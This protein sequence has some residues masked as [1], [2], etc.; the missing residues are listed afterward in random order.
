MTSSLFTFRCM[1]FHVILK[2]FYSSSFSSPP[3]LYIL[4][5][6]GLHVIAE[7]SCVLKNQRGKVVF[8]T[9][10]SMLY[11]KTAPDKYTSGLPPLP[12]PS[13][14]SL[15]QN[16]NNGEA[17]GYARVAPA[18]SY[19]R[20]SSAS[21]HSSSHYDD[22]SVG[23]PQVP[24]QGSSSLCVCVCLKACELVRTLFDVNVLLHVTTR[25]LSNTNT[26]VSSYVNLSFP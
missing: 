13:S 26:F 6:D 17:E 18:G 22:D 5:Q 23:S 25:V 11:D 20:T 15:K 12:S 24:K 19:A 16:S 3:T 1:L 14:S 8:T 21:S 4:H 7:F 9:N 10:K 2:L